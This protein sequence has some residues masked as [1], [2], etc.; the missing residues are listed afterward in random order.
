MS[1]NYFVYHLPPIVERPFWYYG[2]YRMDL[3]AE[4][5]PDFTYYQPY[6][7]YNDQTRTYIPIDPSQEYTWN[8]KKE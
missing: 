2:Y 6:W 4:A 3:K 7:I 5:L 8:S 1:T